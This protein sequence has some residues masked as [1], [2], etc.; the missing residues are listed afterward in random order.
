MELYSDGWCVIIEKDN[1]T[2]FFADASCTSYIEFSKAVAMHI[3]KRMKEN[4]EHGYN[5]IDYIYRKRI[6]WKGN[7]IA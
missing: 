2:C 4:Q 3:I 6:G 1:G 7:N 5:L